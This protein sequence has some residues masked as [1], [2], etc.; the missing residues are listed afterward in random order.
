MMILFV[1]SQTMASADSGSRGVGADEGHA[2]R[3]GDSGPI[4]QHYMRDGKQVGRGCKTLS[5]PNKDFY[6]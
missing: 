3:E 6:K 5:V 4:H 2:A 1:Y